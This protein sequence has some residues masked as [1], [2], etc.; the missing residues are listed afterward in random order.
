[1]P[2]TLP[3]AIYYEQ[4]NWFKPLFSELDRRSIDYVKLFAPTTPGRPKITPKK[5]T[6][7]SSTA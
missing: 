6:P 2:P 1:M 5:N 7:S 4:P 3:I